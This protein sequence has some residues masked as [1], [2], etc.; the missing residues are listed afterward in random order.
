MTVTNLADKA[1]RYAARLS[2]KGLITEDSVREML[3]LWTS[4]EL[5][6]DELNLLTD[7]TMKRLVSGAP[8]FGMFWRRLN[9]GMA[10]RGLDAV[11][12]GPARD[13]F[14]MGLLADDAAAAETQYL[15]A[16][17]LPPR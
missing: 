12:F 7:E 6:Y 15:V 17:R 11:R 8:A 10:L 16:K 4:G 3:D 2:S 1:T 13:Y 5:D 9:E 14:E